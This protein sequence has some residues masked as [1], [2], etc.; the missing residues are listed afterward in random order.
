MW[1][2]YEEDA[3]YIGLDL[4]YFW[5]LNVNQYTKHI[6]VFNKKQQEEL[7]KIDSNNFMLGK[8]IGFAVND[9]K[10]YPQQPFSAVETTSSK[11][12]TDDEME[13]QARRNTIMLGGVIE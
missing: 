1:R 11:V 13:K 4:N 2:S 5:S 6:R 9:P 8:Y 7:Q 10:N 12:M 3:I